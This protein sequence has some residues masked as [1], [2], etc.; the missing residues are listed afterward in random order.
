[1][2]KIL[3]FEKWRKKRVLD[4]WATKFSQRNDRQGWYSLAHF[5]ENCK[6][7]KM[8]VTGP[9]KVDLCKVFR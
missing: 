5:W 7:V 3:T 1:M 8:E 4:V 9:K 2:V 6:K